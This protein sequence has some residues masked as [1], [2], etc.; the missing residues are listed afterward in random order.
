MENTFNHTPGPWHQVIHGAKMEGGYIAICDKNGDW[1]SEAKGKGCNKHQGVGPRDNDQIQA[2]A[3]LI[4]AAPQLLE[5]LTKLVKAWDMSLKTN[6]KYLPTIGTQLAM[7]DAKEVIAAATD[8][9]K[10]TTP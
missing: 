2:N 8:Q 9:T 1:I 5:A 6:G 3:N 4:A 7:S 10:P